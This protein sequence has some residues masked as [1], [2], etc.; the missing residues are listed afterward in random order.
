MPIALPHLF[1]SDLRGFA[2]FLT[3]LRCGACLAA[4][5]VAAQPSSAQAPLTRQ[6]DVW[7]QNYS[8]LKAD[9]SV[10]FGTLSNGLRYAIKHN[11][12]PKDGVSMRMRIGS[13]S[14]DE[15]DDEEGLAHF[16]EHMAFR[17]SANIPDGE[18]VHRLER[19]GLKFGPDTNASTEMQQT[20][21]IFNFPKADQSAVDTGLGIFREIGERLNIAPAAV[22]AEKGVILSEERLRDTPQRQAAMKMLADVLAGTRTAER[23]PDGSTDDVQNATAERLKRFYKANYRP[24][25]ATIVVVGN[26]DTAAIEKEI[27]GKFSDWKPA[28]PE[29]NLAPGTPSPASPV[30][31][32]VKAGAPDQLTLTWVRPLETAADTAELERQRYLR[33]L[34]LTILNNRLSDRALAGGSPYTQAQAGVADDLMD[35]ASISQLGISAPP[36]KWNESLDAVVEERR[37][38]MQDGVQPAD[39]A[40]AKTQLRTALESAVASQATRQSSRIADALVS[41]VDQ[42]S[43]YR[44]PAQELELGGQVLAAATPAEVTAALRAAFTGDGPVLFRSA[45]Q[46]AAGEQALKAELAAAT[47]R[48]LAAR[49]S[50]AAIEWPYTDFG[51]PGAVLS[52]KAD[53]QLGATVVTFANGTRLL[54]KPTDFQ[55]DRIEVRAAFGGG[56]AALPQSL[57]HA[58]WAAPFMALG[59]T[60]K[61]SLAQITQWAQASGKTLSV[62]PALGAKST[63]LTGTTR[64]EDLLTQMQLL[65]AYATDPGFRPEA[66]EKIAQVGPSAAGQ[67]D[68][69]AGAVFGRGVDTVLT[70]DPRFEDTPTSADIAATKAADLKAIFQAPLAGPADITMVGD[71]TVPAAIAAVAKTF[72]AEQPAPPQ[73]VPAVAIDMPEGRAQPYVFEHSGRADQAFYGEYWPMPDYFADPKASVVAD[74]ASALLQSRL[75]DTVR[76]KLGITYSPQTSAVASSQLPG[77]GMF[78]AVIETPSKNFATFRQ[79]LGQ[80]LEELATTPIT[81]DELAR[82]K[83]P[84]LETMTKQRQTNSFWVNQ[85]SAY[86]RDPRIK[87]ATLDAAPMLTAVT[88]ADVQALLKH[89]V[90]GTTPVSVISEAAAGKT[91]QPVAK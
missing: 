13:G 25:N 11:E 72:G 82:A 41:N 34:G 12:T 69:N 49:A 9:P 70:N 53:A 22:A 1:P 45:Q 50:A 73:A 29:E 33:L 10:V 75:V 32:F 8:G 21:Y 81:A 48:P 65:A 23:L 4:L 56:R 57:T 35:T 61:L 58:T 88:A 14:M 46:G 26:V 5:I 74:V 76:E 7:A 54:V 38:L 68:A 15:H 86:L 60:G 19:Q 62:A 36:A 18:V 16:L 79:I 43:V 39:L 63:T 40:R 59:G 80:Q 89:Y 44:S 64:T 87:Q 77:F 27:K 3:K 90:V 31:E 24:D 28:A 91:T 71:V 84:L 55:D 52:Q 67:I 17:G 2:V 42:D 83:Q 66:A 78:G 37:R 6:P 20:V 30:V 47:S 85:L 51:K